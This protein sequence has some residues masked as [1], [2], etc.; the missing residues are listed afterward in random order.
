MP[1][2]PRKAVS[3][4]LS[5]DWQLHTGA[6]AAQPGD[7]NCELTVEEAHVLALRDIAFHLKKLH[8]KIEDIPDS[9]ASLEFVGGS[10]HDGLVSIANSLEGL[11]SAD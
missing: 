5:E 10:I 3:F 7:E 11:K 6:L 8:E 2:Q 1:N 9:S 4:F